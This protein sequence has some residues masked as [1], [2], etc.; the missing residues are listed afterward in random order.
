[1]TS[2]QTI[3]FDV[4]DGIGWI[5]LNRPDSL[6]GIINQMMH[7]LYDCLT[8]VSTRE[9]VRV[10]VLTGA[11]RG[12]CPGADIKHRA[13][14]ASEPEPALAPQHFH[15]ATMLHT[16]PQVTIAAINGACAGAG[17]GWAAACDF[18]FAAK[19]ATFNSAFLNV[20][21]AGDMGGPWTL[22]R[23]LGSAKARELYF[24]PEKFF[25]DDA[26]EIGFVSRVFPDNAFREEVEAIATRLSASAPIALR[27]MKQNFL[28]AEQLNFADYIDLESE[29]HM[30]IMQSADTKEAFAAFVEKRAPIFKGR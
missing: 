5:T 4:A 13:S 23:L 2:Y 10:V 19:S 27:G 21:S 28:A 12:F 11:G 9:D 3:K 14:D 24:L 15:V 16:I 8:S 22:S 6:N 30:R 29:R 7:E 25:A 18:R 26:H 1:M 20:A 17:F